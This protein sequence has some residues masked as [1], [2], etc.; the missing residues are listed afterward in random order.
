MTD[1]MQGGVGPVDFM[2]PPGDA[3][4]HKSQR[5]TSLNKLEDQKRTG[6]V[7]VFLKK[8]NKV[9]TKKQTSRHKVWD[10]RESGVRKGDSKERKSPNEQGTSA[11]VL[12]ATPWMLQT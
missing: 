8:T 1:P 5:T 6:K 9:R 7:K 12:W 2:S 3:D 10:L 11:A 4:E